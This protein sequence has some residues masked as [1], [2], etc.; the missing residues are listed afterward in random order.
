MTVEPLDTWC[1]P[2]S[3]KRG[4]TWGI[5][6]L[7]FVHVSQTECRS[8]FVS[9]VASVGSPS[10]K[11]A[12]LNR[13]PTGDGGLTPPRQRLVH[14]SGFQYPKTAD[15][16]L[17]FQV[18]PV[19]DEHLTTGLRPHR[20]RVAGGGEAAGED[21]DTGSVHLLVERAD[22]ATHRF[23]LAGRVIVV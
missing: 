14:V 20:L 23:V 1:S 2:M 13:R 10:V 15:V 6:R 19:G 8:W 5:R 7:P 12:H 22:I 9:S 3:R 16:L 4:E 17:G 11:R 18:W 21:P